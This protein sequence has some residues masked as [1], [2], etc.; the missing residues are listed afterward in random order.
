MLRAEGPVTALEEVVTDLPR[1]VRLTG[2]AAARLGWEVESGIYH[3]TAAAVTHL[4]SAVDTELHVHLEHRDGRLSVRVDD[5][6][7][8]PGSS[9]GLREALAGDIERLAALGGEAE[10]AEHAAGGT[11]T[12][13]LPDRLE[14][15]VESRTRS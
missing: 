3:L 7:L 14:P 10:V 6:A 9:K 2:G 15:L 8:E 12:A 13:W 11:V 5:P 1:P 4:G